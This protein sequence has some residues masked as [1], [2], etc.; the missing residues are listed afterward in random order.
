MGKPK[1]LTFM[2]YE[3][4]VLFCEL[5][6]KNVPDSHIFRPGHVVA[7]HALV[8]LRDCLDKIPETE[9]RDMAHGLLTLT[10]KNIGG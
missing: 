10:Q 7:F 9:D 4:G 2:R 8:H 1:E 6:K 5:C 3:N